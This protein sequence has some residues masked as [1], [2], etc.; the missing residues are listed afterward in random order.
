[1]KKFKLDFSKYEAEF[2]G[3]SIIYPIRENYSIW[4]RTV[5]MFKNSVELVKATILA[6]RIRNVTADFIMLNEEEAGIL[7]KVIDKH[8]QLT[9]NGKGCLGGVLH[10]EAIC[11]VVNMKEITE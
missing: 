10:E 2:K 11:R 1:M 3:E 4:L 7:K 8:L 9:A 6:K 5:G